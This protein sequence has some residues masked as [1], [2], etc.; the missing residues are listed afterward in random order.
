MLGDF[1]ESQS[2]N[3]SIP[4]SP[5]SPDVFLCGWL[6]SKHQLT[7]NSLSLPQTPPQKKKKPTLGGADNGW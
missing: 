5:I 2:A 6:G 1:N 4:L 3:E 7:N